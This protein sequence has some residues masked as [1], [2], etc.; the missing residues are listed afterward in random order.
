M[1][2]RRS[3]PELK[4]VQKCFWQ[5]IIRKCMPNKRLGKYIEQHISITDY[6]YAFIW[7]QIFQLLLLYWC[8]KSGTITVFTAYFTQVA[9]AS[10]FL[11]V[12]GMKLA[13][14]DP[15]MASYYAPK[16]LLKWFKNRITNAVHR[17]K[18]SVPLFVLLF[19]GKRHQFPIK[20]LLLQHK[21]ISS[22]AASRKV[23][24]CLLLWGF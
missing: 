10:G 12:W 8:I 13:A 11:L 7:L 22:S 23:A 2:Q 14:H 20:L 16:L 24:S 9:T 17:E 3:S 21:H 15:P 18:P 4:F 5:Q 1:P 6:V 19:K